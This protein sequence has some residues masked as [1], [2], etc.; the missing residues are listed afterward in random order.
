[1]TSLPIQPHA[2]DGGVPTQ[3]IQNK[4]PSASGQMLNASDNHLDQTS[5]PQANNSSAPTPKK[6]ADSQ[7]H[8]ADFPKFDEPA[9]DS[10]PLK[11]PPKNSIRC[12]CRWQKECR[13]IQTA[14]FHHDPT[15]K[16][17]GFSRVRVP[18]FIMTN[19]Y[20]EHKLSN[21][22]KKELHVNQRHQDHL[23]ITKDNL[24]KKMLHISKSHL[25][26]SAGGE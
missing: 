10:R 13:K 20:D 26:I 8:S 1:M 7:D 3:K 4:Q 25:P 19:E 23:G 24:N 11:N 9:Q 5:K 22:D 21:N 12:D 18:P 6:N 14:I 2:P 15:N 17:F 16:F